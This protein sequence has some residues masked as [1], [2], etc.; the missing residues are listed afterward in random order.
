ML[1][2]HYNN[3]TTTSPTRPHCNTTQH[4]HYNTL[5]L[6]HTTC[7]MSMSIFILSQ[8]NIGLSNFMYDTEANIMQILITPQNI[9]MNRLSEMH[10]SAFYQDIMCRTLQSQS[11]KRTED[12]QFHSPPLC[13]YVKSH[14]RNSFRSFRSPSLAFPFHSSNS[15]GFH[16]YLTS[17]NPLT[18]ITL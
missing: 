10:W 12:M 14:S 15:M 5:P 17:Q 1:Q 4:D 8:W 13:T 3:T 9:Y 6:H 11:V 7:R 2:Y 18:E 16:D